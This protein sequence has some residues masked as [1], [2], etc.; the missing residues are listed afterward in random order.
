ME[1]IHWGVI[2]PGRIAHAFAKGLAVIDGGKL[3]ASA[4]REISRAEA[5]NAEYGAER[6]YGSYEELVEDPRVDAI[7]IATPHRFHYDQAKLAL[8]AGKPVLCEKP[9]TVN[10]AQARELTDFA[11]AK[12]VLLMEALWTRYLP[13]YGVI[14][15]WLDA[16]LIGDVMHVS[17]TMGFVCP[18]ELEGRMLN[19]DLAGGALL[20]LGVYNVSTS[21]WVFGRN[22]KSFHA[23]VFLGDT[24]VDECTD[25]LLDFGDGA[26]AHFCCSLL[27][28]LRGD[29]QIA[30]TRGSILIHP[31]FWCATQ[32]TLS[33]I[34]RRNESVDRPLRAS[35]FEYEIEAAMK[36]IR[37]GAHEEPKMPHADTL[38]NLQLM[39]A[40][41]ASAGFRY[42]FED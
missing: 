20:D 9:L 18:R 22:P 27:G 24:E 38:A 39:D 34:D 6:A 41:R 26:S 15:E 7:Y 13:I 10:A 16:G 29:F 36:A 23:S 25:A 17:S 19:H 4:S 1:T 12:G 8:E 28:N 14:R 33:T 35:G 11:R 3:Y 40:I 37:A 5:F 21:Q 30:G 2:G 31:L 42:R 32:A